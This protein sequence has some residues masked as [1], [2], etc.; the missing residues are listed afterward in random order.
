MIE[1]KFVDRPLSKSYFEPFISFVI[2]FVYSVFIYNTAT[3]GE[4]S[5]CCRSYSRVAK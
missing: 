5:S 1:Q 2:Y 4:I 3:D